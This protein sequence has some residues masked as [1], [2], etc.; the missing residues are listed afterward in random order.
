[1]YSGIAFPPKSEEKPAKK[2]KTEEGEE[3]EPK[4]QPL[5]GVFGKVDKEKAV[6]QLAWATLNKEKVVKYEKQAN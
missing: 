3:Q 6:Q 4:L 2:A 1:M 5:L